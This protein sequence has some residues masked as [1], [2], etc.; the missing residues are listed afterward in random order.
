MGKK[1]RKDWSFQGPRRLGSL[2][3][4]GGCAP[5]SHTP[6]PSAYT[7]KHNCSRRESLCRCSQI[8]TR[9]TVHSGVHKRCVF[10][11]TRMHVPR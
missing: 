10:T 5:P 8:H 6:S 3:V 11:D 4:K 9:M 7:L 1:E 2:G